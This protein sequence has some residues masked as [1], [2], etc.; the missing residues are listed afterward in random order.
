MVNLFTML[1][2]ENILINYVDFH[3]FEK[4]IYALEGLIAAFL[5]RGKNNEKML[6]I[7]N[8]CYSITII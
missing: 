3:K 5:P 6:F 4:E 1:G 8:L 2:I 7:K